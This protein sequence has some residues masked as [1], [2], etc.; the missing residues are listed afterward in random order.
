MHILALHAH[1]DTP[2]SLSA[3]YIALAIQGDLRPAR[4]LFE[5]LP[6]SG[7][8]ADRE[9]AAQFHLRFLDPAE[10]PT[11]ESHA[12]VDRI[13]TAY[14]D[15]WQQALMRGE[16]VEAAEQR[17]LTALTAALLDAGAAGGHLAAG[18]VY[19]ALAPAL[20]REGF[21]ALASHAA[22]LQDLFVWRRQDVRSVDVELT[23]H[24]RKVR[25]AFLSDFSSLGWK[26][27][28]S[29]GLATTTGWVEDGMLYCVEWAYAPG[30]ENF[31]VSYLKHETRHLADFERFPGLPSTDLEYR[32]KLTE[33]A[34]AS[35]TLPR[36][37]EDFT[38]KSAPNAESPHAEANWRVVRDVYAAL[39]GAP[40]AG[41]LEWTTVDVG[42]VNRVARRL[43]AE[44]TAKLEREMR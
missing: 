6:A 18:N 38:A 25:V 30:T 28:A 40:P 44:D 13:V 5:G 20:E 41:E 33:L 16:S 29:L 9:L 1:A 31:D 39:Y 34:F 36:V 7:A 23:D 12:L 43:L 26:H 8:A 22:P 15:Y 11:P 10:S 21:H 37:L 19:S 2:G 24:A 4:Q 27:Y 35:R 42:R 3:R 14:E 17:L 32:A